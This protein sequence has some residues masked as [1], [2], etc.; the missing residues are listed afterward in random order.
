VLTVALVGADGAGKTTIGRR[1][2][3]L[4]DRPARYVYLGANP[5][6]ATHAL[7]TTRLVHRLRMRRGTAD[8]GGPPS[9][10]RDLGPTR[11]GTILHRSLRS[12]RA[13]GRVAHQIA[14]G[15]Y[16]RS[17]IAWHRA[18]GRVV[19]VDRWYGADHH[20]HELAP[21]QRLTASRRV[22]AAFLRRAFPVPDLVLVLD[23]PADVLHRRKGEG[24]EAELARRRGE[25]LDYLRTVPCGHRIDAA[26]PLDEV[27]ADVV[28]AVETAVAS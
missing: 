18:R 15:T 14:E 19:V 7:P 9:L 3:V 17:A 21:G 27:L 6:S 13:G 25:Y 1:L 5:A 20:A 16:Q 8:A 11:Q 28:A 24:T 26:R 2:P 10:D 23:A 22:R 4:L 12:T